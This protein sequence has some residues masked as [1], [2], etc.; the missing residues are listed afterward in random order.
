M[1]TEYIKDY[2]F[3]ELKQFVLAYLL[4]AVASVGFYTKTSVENA[5][6]IS[7]L[8]SM[9]TID[10]L[11]GAICALVFVLNELWS[12]GAKSKI[13]YHKMPSDTVFTDIST[14]K[15]DTSG[16]DQDK[17][18]SMYADMADAS[19]NQQTAKWNLLLKDSRE[20]NSGN[21]VEA[22]RMQLM[23]RD[24][25]VTT[26]SLLIMNIIALGVLMIV[27]GSVLNPLKALWL[28]LVYLVVMFF[29]TRTAARSRAK[30]FVLLVIKNDVQKNK[31]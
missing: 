23:T 30:R 20:C 19:A 11:V 13:V 3:K 9:V 6:L 21:V 14:G 26:I 1:N 27:A 17:A 29:V 8:F 31:E 28:P 12:D 2:R 22:E 24:I 18:K 16:F 4:L 5:G 7:S 25:C 10:V 15:I